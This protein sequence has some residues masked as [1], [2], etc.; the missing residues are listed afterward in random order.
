MLS[1]WKEIESA[2]YQRTYGRDTCFTT[3]S[4]NNKCCRLCAAGLVMKDCPQIEPNHAELVLLKPSPVL[5]YQISSTCTRILVDLQNG[6]P[7][8]LPDYMRD[9]VAPQLPGDAPARRHPRALSEARGFAE[10]TKS[11]YAKRVISVFVK[12][13]KLAFKLPALIQFCWTKPISRCGRRELC[14]SVCGKIFLHS[15]GLIRSQPKPTKTRF[16]RIACFA[17]ELFKYT[18]LARGPYHWRSDG[19]T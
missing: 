16:W 14:N 17:D 15:V 19:H 11:F 9:T 8:D 18:S 10:Q 3:Y 6:V 13:S 5:V 7:R 4:N 2:K 1:Y 12:P